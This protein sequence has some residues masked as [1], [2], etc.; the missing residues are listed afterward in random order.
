MGLCILADNCDEPM[1]KKLVTPVLV[2]GNWL[3]VGKEGG[4]V[5][6]WASLEHPS[7]VQDWNFRAPCTHA[8]MHVVRGVCAWTVAAG[9][10]RGSGS[11]H[12]HPSSARAHCNPVQWQPYSRTFDPATQES[13]PLYSRREEKP[14]LQQRA[15]CRRPRSPGCLCPPAPGSGSQSPSSCCSDHS[16]CLL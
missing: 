12:D 1:Y 16:L 2:E 10:G 5:V 8:K 4:G 14:A 3:P 11:V 13:P 15:Q 6:R 7:T 9:E